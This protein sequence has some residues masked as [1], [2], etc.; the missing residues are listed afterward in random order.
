L[1]NGKIEIF[2][3]HPESGIVKVRDHKAV[4]SRIKMTTSSA[5]FI[6]VFN[7]IKKS[8]KIIKTYSKCRRNSKT[9]YLTF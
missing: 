7:P 9:F 2:L 4:C 1:F 5:T 8:L 6:P 3:K